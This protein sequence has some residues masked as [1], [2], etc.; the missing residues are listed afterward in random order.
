M[1][2]ITIS[3]VP[4]D[5][6]LPVRRVWLQA[7]DEETSNSLGE[8]LGQAVTMLG[9]AR[10]CAVAAELV[11]ELLEG[12][13]FDEYWPGYAEAVE[14]LLLAANKIVAGWHKYDQIGSRTCRPAQP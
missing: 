9:A 14:D 1:I 6:G 8:A 4:S 13:K 12:E 3:S 7:N 10:S 11:I 2:R 5:P